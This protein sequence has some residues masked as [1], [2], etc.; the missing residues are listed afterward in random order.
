MPPH[1]SFMKSSR[2]SLNIF[3]AQLF[4]FVLILVLSPCPSL[5]FLTNGI[6]PASIV[7]RSGLIFNQPSRKEFHSCIYSSTQKSDQINKNNNEGVRLNKVLKETHSRREADA[8]IESGRVT[9]N[10]KPIGSKGGFKVIPYVD[11]VELDG[12]I[13]RGWEKMNGFYAPDKKTSSSNKK[14]KHQNNSPKYTNQHFEYIKYW[15]PK[16]VTCTTEKSVK[17]NIVHE[18]QRDGYHPKHRVYPVGRLDKDTTGKCNT[19][20]F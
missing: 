20:I 5:S 6:Q 17:S 13:V 9:I 8:L 11:S 3:H 15:K 2:E 4:I 14:L 18:I 16:G 1:C 7:N 19:F 12:K 10:G